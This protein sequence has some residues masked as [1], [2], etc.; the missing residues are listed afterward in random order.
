MTGAG[1][2]PRSLTVIP[3]PRAQKRTSALLGE[4][5]DPRAVSCFGR[6]GFDIVAGAAGRDFLRA[7]DR[8]LVVLGFSAV[9]LPSWTSLETSWPEPSW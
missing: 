8:L 1:I 2:R 3:L 5:A 9:L 4:R 7:E 6:F